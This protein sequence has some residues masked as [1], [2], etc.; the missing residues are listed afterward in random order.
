MAKTGRKKAGTG[1]PTIAS[2][3][4]LFLAVCSPFQKC[5]RD[6]C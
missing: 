3:F 2:F 4:F 1:N 5:P 6:K